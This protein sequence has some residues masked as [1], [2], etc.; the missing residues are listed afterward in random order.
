VRD[1]AAEV[2]SV[3]DRLAEGSPRVTSSR[4]RTSPAPFQMTRAGTQRG[5]PGSLWR[6][7]KLASDFDSK[8]D[9]K[10]GG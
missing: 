6:A 4:I 1:A 9:S 5:S 7:H 2:R 10:T 3:M 8:T